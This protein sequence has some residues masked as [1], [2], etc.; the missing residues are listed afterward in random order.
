MAPH[1]FLAVLLAALLHAGWNVAIKSSDDKLLD[2]TAGC[3]ALSFLP[4]LDRASVPWLA[5]SIALHVV[6][7]RLVAAIYGGGELSVAYPLMRGLPPLLTA[8]AAMVVLQ[9]AL[10]GL[11]WLAVGL[12]SSGILLLSWGWNAAT[13]HRSV[14]FANVLFIVAYTLV[15]GVG[16]R[17]S[18]APASYV[19]WLFAGL[20][21]AML[22]LA[23][24]V[25]GRT[26]LGDLAQRARMGLIGGLAAI[27][28]YGLVLWAMTQAPVALVA[29]L[30]EI[31]VIFGVALAAV[32]L[33][34]RFGARRWVAVVL[35]A[36]GAMAAR[37]A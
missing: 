1:V 5:A 18:R 3:A 15:D 23:A 7:F 6:Y 20:A 29:A 24:A 36:A 13:G 22:L 11:G 8:L 30:R 14:V 12:L 19:S 10:T 31:A 17:L 34:E 21:V 37:A 16:V 9:E 28:A 4:T 35:V 25:R 2:T 33:N 32:V 26:V 27:G